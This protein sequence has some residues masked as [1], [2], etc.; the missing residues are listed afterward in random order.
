MEQFWRRSGVALG[1][2]WKIVGLVVVAVSALLLLGL[3]QLEFATGQDSYL[4]DDSQISIDNVGFQEQFGGETVVL[5]FSATD[6]DARIQD[7]FVGDNLA[8]LERITAE[9][10]QIGETSAVI[11]PLVSLTYS[12]ALLKGPGRDALLSAQARDP[13]PDGAAAR[14]ADV[15]LSGWV[16]RRRDHGGMGGA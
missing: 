7:L 12:D 8:E 5:L 3:R 2:H 16:H 6:D 14:G 4:N 1:K 15:S 11:T 9:L 10:E 13:D